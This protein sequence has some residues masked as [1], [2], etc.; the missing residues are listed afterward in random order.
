MSGTLANLT[1]A[2][3]R[4]LVVEDEVLIAMQIEEILLDLGCVVVG[5]VGRL[6]AAMSLAADQALDAAILD[7]N[8]L[9]GLVYPVAERLSARGI[10]F[11]LASGYGSW[12]LPEP[13]R[14]LPRLTK[15]FRRL[16]LENGV[17]A[18]CT[19]H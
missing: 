8:I 10:P 9:G 15:P 19:P 11:M 16:E 6:D 5:A 18:L 17:R 4:I 13:L 2:N 12:A 14:D 7:V 3:R 1:L